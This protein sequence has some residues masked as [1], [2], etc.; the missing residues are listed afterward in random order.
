[1]AN[2]GGVKLVNAA[3]ITSAGTTTGQAVPTAG[4]KSLAVES[5]LT[6]GSGGTTVK[7]YI[8]TRVGGG[9]WRDIMCHTFTTATAKKWSKTSVY[10]ALTA[11]QAVSD[12][13]LA[14][15]TILDGLLGDEVRVKYVV[16]GTYAGNTSLSVRA[17]AK[18]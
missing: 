4:L 16:T 14:D 17:A 7:V 1:M 8:Q 6:Y 12:A 9:T 2:G 18:Y 13:A 3:S 5:A 11:S 10:A 15:D